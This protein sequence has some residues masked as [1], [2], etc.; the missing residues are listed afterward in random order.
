MVTSSRTL[1]TREMATNA[2]E[3]I[4]DAAEAIMLQEAEE[5]AKMKTTVKAEVRAV[6]VV[7]E[8]AMEKKV[9]AAEETGAED[10]IAM[11]ITAE[12]VAVKDVVK[13]ERTKAL[14]MASLMTRIQVKALEMLSK[15]VDIAKDTK[16]NHVNSG[17]I[18]I[19]KMVLVVEREAT[20]KVVPAEETGEGNTKERVM[21]MK[22]RRVKKAK[23]ENADNVN[24]VRKRRS[25][26]SKRKRKKSDSLMMTISLQRR[27]T[28]LH[29]PR[30]ESTRN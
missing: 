13:E 14:A 27:L 25:R 19:A 15:L 24:P 6:A 9:K 30:A 28:I 1:Q 8:T 22:K 10:A 18:M 3:R 11:A 23:A 20:G 21:S 26:L 7:V 2:A 29:K 16:E 17:M 12:E 4:T 5:E